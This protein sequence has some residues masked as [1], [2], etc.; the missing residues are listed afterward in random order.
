MVCRGFRVRMGLHSGLDSDQHVM[1]N[2]VGF[3]SVWTHA[4]FYASR[5]CVEHSFSTMHAVGVWM[6]PTAGDAVMGTCLVAHRL[7]P[8][9]GDRQ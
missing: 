8:T 7:V 5:Y 1:L 2:K 4:A 3:Q 6:M 9:A